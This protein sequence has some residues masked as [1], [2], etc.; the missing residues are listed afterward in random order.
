M[1]NAEKYDVIIIGAGIAGLT[2]AFKLHERGFSV[3]VLESASHSGGNVYTLNHSPYR[4]ET[5]PHSFMGSSEYIWELIRELNMDEC[6][7]PAQPVAQNRYILRD[8]RIVPLPL[9]LLSF[10]ATPLLS[11]KGKARLAMEPFIPG[12]ATDHGTAWEFFVRRFGKEAAM[13]IMSPFISGVYAGDARI[14][15]ARA[16][17]PKFWTFEKETGSMIRGAMLYMWRKKR[18]LAREGKKPRKG[19]Y[20]FKGGLGKITE[21]L[22]KKLGSR[23]STEMP[24][25][26]LERD[27]GLWTVQSGETL[28][29]APAV[30]SAIPPHALKELVPGFCP[31]LA[32]PL[33]E[34]P[35]APV[36]LIH[37]TARSDRHPA[38]GFGFLVPRL[39]DTRVLGTLFP[40]ELFTGRAP[41]KQHLFAS[42][43][44]GMT[45]PEAAS[46]PDADLETLVRREHSGIL[47]FREDRMET[48]RI[49]RYPAAIPQMLPGHPETIDGILKRLK[50]FP[51]I[52]LAG[53]YITGV[54]IEHAVKSGYTAA[55]SCLKYLE[56]KSA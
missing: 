4:L 55:V 24:V 29:A 51:D 39:Y 45:D 25:Q 8:G 38:P 54:G 37:W 14:L 46:L 6:L 52:F 2:A 10:L 43:Y 7:E 40:S 41:G 48:L 1:H 23:L 17:F 32:A 13:Y 56:R 21:T 5:G 27:K 35:M 26:S 50:A 16:A 20:S 42:F 19:M 36:V 33:G 15:G 9:S 49:L 30:I 53:N 12:D 22:S 47:G 28:F 44:G 34:I 31:D 11:L 3:R 18:R